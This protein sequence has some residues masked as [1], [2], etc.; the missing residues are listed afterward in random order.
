MKLYPTLLCTLLSVFVMQSGFAASD[1]QMDF[2]KTLYQTGKNLEKGTEIVEMYAD[3]SLKQAFNL[4]ADT[5]EVCGFAA[6]V[7]WQSQDPE[8]QK[9][10]SFTKVGQNQVKVNMAKKNYDHASWVTYKL[11]CK[12]NVCKISDTIN[13]SGS[14]K[15]NIYDECS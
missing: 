13:S 2:V 8:Y 10:L 9:K 1:A 6:D 5:G 14:L 12:G 11:N 3:E 15:K 7:M 4:H